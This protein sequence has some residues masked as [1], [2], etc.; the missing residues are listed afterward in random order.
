M[1][2]AYFAYSFVRFDRSHSVWLLSLFHRYELFNLLINGWKP[3]TNLRHYMTRLMKPLFR[4]RANISTFRNR[5]FD[6]YTSCSISM[7]CIEFHHLPSGK[8]NMNGLVYLWWQNTHSIEREKKKKEIDRQSIDI[9]SVIGHYS[10]DKSFIN[11]WPHF[12]SI[13][14][15]NSQQA[16]N[17]KAKNRRK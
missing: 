8:P 15:I 14:S 13:N 2:D 16:I 12:T 1:Y 7:W 10:I 17:R 9:L 5:N 4:F 6:S 11:K 3:F